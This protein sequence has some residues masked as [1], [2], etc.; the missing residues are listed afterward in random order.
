MNGPGVSSHVSVRLL[1]G[2]KMSVLVEGLTMRPRDGLDARGRPLCWVCGEPIRSIE[3]VFCPDGQPVHFYC[4][5]A[6]RA[7]QP[8]SA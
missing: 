2:A 8:R 5:Q 6:A 3:T 1:E 4:F 7:K